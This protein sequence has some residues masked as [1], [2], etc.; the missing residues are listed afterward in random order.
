MLLNLGG[1]LNWLNVYTFISVCGFLKLF[2]LFKTLTSF[3]FHIIHNFG[4]HSILTDTFY[5][6][7]SLIFSVA[8]ELFASELFLA[9][10][11]LLDFP[12]RLRNFNWAFK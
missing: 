9:L 3:S 6:F 12:I 4:T 5:R 2:H 1:F 11:R 8:D 10:K 7:Q